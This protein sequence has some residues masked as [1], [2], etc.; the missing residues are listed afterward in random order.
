MR[1]SRKKSRNPLVWSSRRP[2]VIFGSRCSAGRMLATEVPRWSLP[3][4]HSA[5]I[6]AEV[7][8]L[9]TLA[10]AKA[11]SGVTFVS[12]AMSARP[13]DPRHTVPS[14]KRI[15]AEMP[16]MAERSRRRSRRD[17]R[18]ASRAGVAVG[19]GALAGTARAVRV[20]DDATRAASAGATE[21]GEA[22]A[23]SPMTRAAVV[24]R[25]SMS[26]ARYP[27]SAAGTI[28]R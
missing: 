8:V 13:P 6:S 23:A 5:R 17:W 9:L 27:G 22:A 18:A 1:A 26:D 14:G 24:R 19:P 4:S 21:S 7:N 12:V 2:T 3:S 28:G 11:V 15:A 10:R 20:A 25:R 16:G